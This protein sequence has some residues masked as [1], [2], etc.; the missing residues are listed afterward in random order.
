MMRLLAALILPVMLAGCCLH[1]DA[2]P[3]ETSLVPADALA[4]AFADQ[5]ASLPEGGTQHFASSPFGAAVVSGGAFYLSG[6][7]QECR[8]AFADGSAGRFRFAVCRETGG[9]WRFIPTVFERT[10][11]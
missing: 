6:L 9:A 10:A 8:S 3:T 7:G 5:V 4:D 11:P 1:Q 2:A